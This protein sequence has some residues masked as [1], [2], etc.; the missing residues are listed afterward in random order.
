ML[1]PG[2][3]V[4]SMIPR[5]GSGNGFRHGNLWQ[6]HPRS[7][8]HS[9]VVCWGL[10]FDLLQHCALLQ[11]HVQRGLVGFGLNHEMRDFRTGRKKKLDLVV[12]RPRSEPSLRATTRLS[13]AERADTLGIVLDEEA[14]STLQG[15]PTPREL[16]VGAVH[17]AVEAKACMTAFSKARPRLYDELSSESS[18]YSRKFGARNRRGRSDREHLIRV[19]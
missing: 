16:P 9:Q 4:A 11:S 6:Y 10:L 17:V 12:C 14:R 3:L 19:H 2:I 1:G 13:F 18:D 8:H 5:A 15:L 7:D